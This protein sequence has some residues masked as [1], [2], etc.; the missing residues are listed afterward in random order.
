MYGSIYR[1]DISAPRKCAPP[2]QIEVPSVL[3]L[4]ILGLLKEAPLHGYELKKRLGEALGT[5]WGFSYGS[6]YPALNRLEKAGAIEITDPAHTTAAAAP[7]PATGSISGEAAA[8]RTRRVTKPSRRTRKAYRITDRGHALF[9]ELLAADAGVGTDEDR[10]FA[11]KVAFCRYLPPDLRLELL[12]RRRAYLVEKLAKARRALTP[13]RTE[14]DR[15]AP[16]TYTRSLIEHG[17]NATVLDLEWVD[18][19][20]AAETQGGT[21]Q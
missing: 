8:A 2:D 12:H 1:S 4:A 7:I 21:T 11:L 6:L 13:S 10:S 18:G 14:Q 20:I 9:A 17:T 5:F 15:P 19:L 16:D 3:E